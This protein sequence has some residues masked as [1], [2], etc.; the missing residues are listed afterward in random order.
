MPQWLKVV[1][2]I[3]LLFV[4][5]GIGAVFY[6]VHWIKANQPR[7]QQEA[8]KLHDEGLSFGRGKEPADC[9]DE[10]LRR[11]KENRGFAGQIRTRVFL[12]GCL[13]GSSLP[14]AFCE[15]LPRQN[16]FMASAQW[17]LNECQKRGMRNDQTCAN[18]VMA[19]IQRCDKQRSQP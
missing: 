1:L 15:T 6:G 2:G 9:I 8:R 13:D 3:I 5:F 7:L 19:V 4:L 10:A 12:E 14:T 18:V 11:Y 16:E 17:A